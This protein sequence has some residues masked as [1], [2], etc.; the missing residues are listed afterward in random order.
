MFFESDSFILKTYIK[1]K[2]FSKPLALVSMDLKLLREILA[3]RCFS[4]YDPNEIVYLIDPFLYIVGL[5]P[6][7]DFEPIVDEGAVNYVSSSATS[8][9]TWG[10]QEGD[11]ELLKS[12][13]PDLVDPD[14]YDVE[15]PTFV[16]TKDITIRIDLYQRKSL[17]VKVRIHYANLS[18]DGNVF[19]RRHDHS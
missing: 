7:M 3:I 8:I 18:P 11:A 14:V 16:K 9:F 15:D 1:Q 10:K 2:Q 17:P 12:Q 5:G 6:D 13:N 4:H 19:N